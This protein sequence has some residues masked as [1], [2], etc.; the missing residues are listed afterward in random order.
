MNP[1]KPVKTTATAAIPHFIDV[2][3]GVTFSVLL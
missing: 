1:P 2:P 3:L